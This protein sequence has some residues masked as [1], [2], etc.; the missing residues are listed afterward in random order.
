MAE[1]ALIHDRDAGIER[2]EDLAGKR[3][4]IGNPGSGQ[5]ATMEVV[6][7]AMG[8]TR[9]DFQLVTEL[10]AAQQ[11][12]ALCHNRIQALV[13]TVGHPNR[14]VAKAVELC[15]GK[16]ARVDGPVIDKLVAGRPYYAYTRIPAEIYASQHEPVET[17]GMLATLSRVVEIRTGFM[18]TCDVR[19]KDRRWLTKADARSLTRSMLS[20]RLSTMPQ[21]LTLRTI[22][23]FMRMMVRILLKSWA[24]P[25][26]SR[27]RASNFCACW[28]C[29]S[30][31]RRSASDRRRS[32][33][34]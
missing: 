21:S 33:T 13:Y 29:S 26:E 1:D 3:V 15:N 27:P 8:W 9:E 22:S 23:T 31:F 6:M 4:N 17:F 12:L 19:L 11:S 25:P 2:L 32:E 28:I 16:I 24:T 34:S 7:R 18:S 14:S 20:M 5:R 30:S 10:P